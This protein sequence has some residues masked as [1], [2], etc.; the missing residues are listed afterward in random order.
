MREDENDHS[1][2]LLRVDPSAA[3]STEPLPDTDSDPVDGQLPYERFRGPGVVAAAFALR[4]GEHLLARHAF[5]WCL[6]GSVIPNCYEMFSRESVCRGMGWEIVHSFGPHIAV[7]RQIGSG[8]T[9][10][11]EQAD[12]THRSAAQK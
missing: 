6:D 8:T 10:T 1:A 12:A 3:V 11:K 7:V 4:E 5:R 9:A 2:S